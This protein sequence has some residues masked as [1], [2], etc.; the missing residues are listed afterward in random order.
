MVY[1]TKS[2]YKTVIPTLFPYLISERLEFFEW[3]FT[4]ST[5]LFIIIFIFHYSCIYKLS[6]LLKV[7]R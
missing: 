7:L 3:Q 6:G 4:R 5:V 1:M 2:L